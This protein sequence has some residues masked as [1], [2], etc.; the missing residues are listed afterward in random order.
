MTDVA[1]PTFQAAFLDL[2]TTLTDL[3]VTDGFDISDATSDLLMVGVA[4]LVDE[5]DISAGTFSQEQV[6]HGAAGYIKETGT[7]N[8]LLVAWNGSA[9]DSGAL[10][11]RTAAFGHLSA[12]NAAI[13][14]DRHLGVTAFDLVVGT[15]LTSGDIAEDKGTGATCA[16]SFT[17][18]YTALIQ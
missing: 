11:A 16:V 12:L 9:T 4:N 3:R 18:N 7:L 8:A 5:S 6:G 10:A 17:V 13:R 2:A 15:A 1:W 14:A